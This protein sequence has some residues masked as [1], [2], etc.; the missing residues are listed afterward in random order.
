MGPAKELLFND[1]FHTFNLINDK[2]EKLL[3]INEKIIA[4]TSQKIHEDNRVSNI[5]INVLAITGALVGI[6]FKLAHH[7]RNHPSYR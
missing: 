7:P 1:M 5:I 4:L 2:C 6:F 3:S